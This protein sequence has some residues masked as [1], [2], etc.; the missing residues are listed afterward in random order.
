MPDP[1]CR[2]P[3]MSVTL[4][5]DQVHDMTGQII[6]PEEAPA[7]RL[8]LGET[9]RRFRAIARLSQEALGFE[10]D[11][12]RN[13]VGAIERGEINPTLR[14]LCKLAYGLDVPA[15]D[16]LGMAEWLTVRRRRGQAGAVRP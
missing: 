16:L 14:V 4:G 11:L 13:Y 5:R 1:L 2:V 8:A 10:A 7:L 9:V 6:P 3:A 15:S 12:H